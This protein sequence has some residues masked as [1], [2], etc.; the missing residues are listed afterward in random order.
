MSY[1]HQ[2]ESIKKKRNF[3][4]KLLRSII[5]FIYIS[6]NNNKSLFQIVLSAF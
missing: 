4:P 6:S 3:Q 5:H 1:T 2:F